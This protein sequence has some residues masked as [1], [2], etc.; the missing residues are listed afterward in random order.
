MY[1]LA[2]EKGFWLPDK[3]TLAQ[4]EIAGVSIFT[5]LLMAAKFNLGIHYGPPH[6]WQ[7]CTPRLMQLADLEPY[8]EL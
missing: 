2:S 4:Y 1:C 8:S 3:P 7:C 6:Q 5:S